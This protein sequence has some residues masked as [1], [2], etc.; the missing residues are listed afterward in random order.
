MRAL[1]IVVAA[2]FLA[3][4][5][6]ARVLERSHLVDCEHPANPRYHFNVTLKHIHEPKEGLVKVKFIACA[7]RPENVLRFKGMRISRDGHAVSNRQYSEQKRLCDH[8]VQPSCHD[9][10]AKPMTH[11]QSDKKHPYCF[12]QNL[13]FKFKNDISDTRWWFAELTGPPTNNRPVEPSIMNLCDWREIIAREP[14]DDE[15]LNEP[16]AAKTEL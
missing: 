7:R 6:A 13:R 1:G 5:S 9:Q 11:P 12:E 4:C 14:Y 15:I 3:S 16:S 2:C 10:V 8:R